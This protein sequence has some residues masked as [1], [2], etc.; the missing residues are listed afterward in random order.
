MEVEG[1]FF[2]IHEAL[3]IELDLA[4]PHASVACQ[5][6]WTATALTNPDGTFRIELAPTG[7]GA[8]RCG[9][10]VDATGRRA[11]IARHF[12]GVVV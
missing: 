12:G 8:L 7:E 3:S 1:K 4:E 2:P 9:V 11:K 5:A 6:Q 10:L